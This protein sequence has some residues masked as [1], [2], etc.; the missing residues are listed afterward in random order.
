MD[1]TSFQSLTANLSEQLTQTTT[2]LLTSL[3][4]GPD[5]PIHPYD[6]LKAEHFPSDHK[7]PTIDDIEHPEDFDHQEA[8]DAIKAISE[9]RQKRHEHH[10][11]HL[12]V[13]HEHEHVGNSF[14]EFKDGQFVL[15]K[16]QL[17]SYIELHEIIRSIPVSMLTAE[18]SV[19]ITKKL[20]THY[21]KTFSQ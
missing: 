21:I 20:V 18:N 1:L 14:A 11:N 8:I 10:H 19:A 7:F 2:A 16:D 15:N 6:R 5:V 17:K 3:G 12:H 13:H 4:D 9:E